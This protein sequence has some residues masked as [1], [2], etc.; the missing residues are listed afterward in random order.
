MV[1]ITAIVPAT[2][3]PVTLGTCI[4]SI[5]RAADPPEEL[6][7]VEEPSAL[8]AAEAR[9]VGA[10]SASGDVLVFVDGDVAVHSDAFTR[11]RA[12]F[13]AEPMLTAVFGSYDDEPAGPDVVSGF[14]NLL[15]HYVHHESPGPA[16]TFWTGL[17]SVRRDAFASVG[18]FDGRLQW[19]ED[20]DLGVRLAAKGERIVLDPTIQGT[21]LKRWTLRTMLWT[22]FVGRGIPWTV[23]LLRHRTSATT[24]NLGWR[25]RLSATSCLIGCAALATRRPRLAAASL[26]ALVVLNRSFYLLLL[27]KRGPRQAAL[28]VGLHTL[29]HLTGIAAVPAGVIA[30]L[31]EQRSATRRSGVS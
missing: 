10:S 2:N 6:I 4:D 5:R 25:H 12:R 19:L 9:N 20:V 29:H 31:F 23:L 28:G 8:G 27:R 18:G 14:R 24:L 21:H 1:R 30:F 22:D 7:V 13:D 11:I 15:H 16:D 17:G 26:G 3:R